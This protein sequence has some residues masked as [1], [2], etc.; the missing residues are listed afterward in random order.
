LSSFVEPR[1]FRP[2]HLGRARGS[3]ASTSRLSELA[4]R[5]HGGIG[6]HFR[7]QVLHQHGWQDAL[8]GRQAQLGAWVKYTS[9][10][11]SMHS[12]VCMG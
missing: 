5:T 10:M 6:W 3:L 1:L 11:P 9:E 4:Q 7:P 12:D 2:P 8:Q